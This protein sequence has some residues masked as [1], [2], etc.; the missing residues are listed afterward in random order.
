MSRTRFSWLAPMVLWPLA[1]WLLPEPTVRPQG[2]GTQRTDDEAVFAAVLFVLVSEVPWR[3]LPRTFGV[4]W[5]HAHRRFGQ[6]SEAGLWERLREAARDPRFPGNVQHW[7]DGVARSA[8]L[9]GSR[10]TELTAVVPA[11]PLVGPPR[12]PGRPMVRTHEKGNFT[13]RLFGPHR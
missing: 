11:A 13:A 6:W 10:G 1:Q 5:Q 9:R 2:G 12:P 7:A 3:A 4:S 8:A